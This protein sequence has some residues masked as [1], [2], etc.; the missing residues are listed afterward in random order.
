MLS[1]S[2]IAALPLA[3][4][5]VATALTTPAA[6]TPPLSSAQACV[7]HTGPRLDCFDSY[8]AA[9]ASVGAV[10]PPGSAASPNCPS[11]WLCL[12]DGENWTGR[13]LQ[14]RDEYWQPLSAWAFDRKTSSWHNNQGKDDWGHLAAD[15]DQLD[16]PPEGAA[17][18]MGRYNVWATHVNG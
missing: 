11:G 12:Y 5:A 1:R 2:Q 16:L 8:A 4:A 3:A 7:V 10:P 15:G 18:T 6:A 9:D 13:R 14:F 17:A